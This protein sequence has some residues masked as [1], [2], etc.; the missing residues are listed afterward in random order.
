MKYNKKEITQLLTTLFYT[1]ALYNKALIYL[2][3]IRCYITYKFLLAAFLARFRVCTT[4]HS[5][6][7]IIIIIIIS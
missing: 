3:A 5:C 4:I 2:T 7:N 1:L 6:N